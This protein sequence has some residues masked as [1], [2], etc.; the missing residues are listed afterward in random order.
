MI[1]PPIKRHVSLQPF[2]RDHYVGLVQAQHLMA[3]A[4]KPPADRRKAVAE[5]LQAWNS[6]IETHFT[7]EERL[8]GQLASADDCAQLRSEH[9]AIRGL[10]QQA[11]VERKQTEPSAQ[12]ARELGQKLNDHIRWEE[13][14]LFPAI[15]RS[16]GQ[17]HLD[18]LRAETAL[19]EA[20]R[21]RAAACRPRSVSACA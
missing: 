2:S 3:A 13:R 9:D 15:E 1:N 7:D 12:W 4:A 8:L 16:L 14:H 19:I 6:E 17:K 21:P 20:S 10:A 5:F 11:F 18:N